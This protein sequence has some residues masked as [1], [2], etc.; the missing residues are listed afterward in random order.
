MQVFLSYSQAD[1]ALASRVRSA[2]EEAGFQVWDAS[3]NILP[4][5]NWAEK[6]SEALKESEAMVVLLTRNSVQ[7]S[8]VQWE[9]GYALGN[10]A[11]AKRLIP[12]LA[13]DPESFPPEKIPWILNRLRMVSLPEAEGTDEEIRKIAQLLKEA[14]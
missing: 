2:L 9:I 12:V 1:D 6:I 13:G 5:D 3:R 4:G 14:A 8:Q 7:S 10:T 11:Y